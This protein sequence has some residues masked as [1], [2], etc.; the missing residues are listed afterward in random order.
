MYGLL[1]LSLKRSP[2]SVP[3]CDWSAG[4]LLDI[5]LTG[6]G[7]SRRKS[8]FQILS[9]DSAFCLW[10]IDSVDQVQSWS[11][12]SIDA[13]AKFLESDLLRLLQRR[14]CRIN[15]PNLGQRRH[16]Q[17]RDVA[18]ARR[19]R[20]LA[21]K[22]SED[23]VPTVYVLGLLASSDEWI[24]TSTEATD[25]RVELPAWL[26]RAINEL[27]TGADTTPRFLQ[28]VKRAIDEQIDV[29][30]Y[31]QSRESEMWR[32]DFP[33]VRTMLEKFILRE[34]HRDESRRTFHQRLEQAKLAAM[35]ELAY[36]A[37][38]EINNPLANISTR[39][40]S[41]LR[42]E[43]DPQRR[44]QLA[45]ITSQAF[46][47]HEMISD[48]MLFAKPP[49][50][51]REQINVAEFLHRFVQSVHQD[52]DIGQVDIVLEDPPS[53]L[54]VNVDPRQLDVALRA[55][56]KNASE[57]ASSDIVVQ[58][59]AQEW[60]VASRVN[61]QQ[62]WERAIEIQ[63]SDNGPGI[64]QEVR[65]HLFDPYYSGREA[66]RGLG[67]GLSKAWRIVQE[68]GG[69]IV[70]DSEGGHGVRFSIRLPW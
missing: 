48:M 41:L 43:E 20:E 23:A 67:F 47:A 59:R 9:V 62:E 60:S 68:H 33:L 52:D 17:D 22:E 27:Q 21:L 50:L 31:V 8:L 34:T 14:L 61:G 38:H 7:E 24:V 19:A 70:V 42:D 65:Q 18:L 26:R 28:F 5:L 37:S 66:G 45:T 64:P 69:E 10:A 32:T 12:V 11:D 3:L 63:V 30:T 40:Q 6:D 25:G 13:I 16:R 15:D 55:M 2:H 49:K 46:R 39:S 56:V 53:D 44:R 1:G 58:I 54:R 29:Q 35:K 4:C 36:G 51:N 57:I